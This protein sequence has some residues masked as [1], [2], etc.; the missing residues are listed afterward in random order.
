MP[1]EAIALLGAGGH[2]KVVYDAIRAARLAA[3]IIVRDDDLALQDSPFLDVRVVAPIGTLI[4]LPKLVHVAIGANRARY[5]LAERL[6]DAGKALLTVVHPAASVSERGEI[7]GGV[8]IAAGAV[9]AA[10]SRVSECAI[11]NHRAVVDHDCVVGRCVHVAPA[12]TLG[13]GVHVGDGALIGSGAVVLPGVSIGKW[14]V[15]GAGAVVNR[16]VAEG[17]IVYGVPARRKRDA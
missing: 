14:A 2:A 10:A 5:E 9:V 17:E 7:A 12:A 8:F 6:G 15:V 11:I 3:H 16:T 13:G 4:D 1:I